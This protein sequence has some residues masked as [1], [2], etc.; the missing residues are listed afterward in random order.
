MF[1]LSLLSLK[2]QRQET[3]KTLETILVFVLVSLRMLYVFLCGVWSLKIVGMNLYI[4]CVFMCSLEFKKR[5]DEF[6]T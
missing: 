1:E 5:G 4:V 6:I 2:V 3:T